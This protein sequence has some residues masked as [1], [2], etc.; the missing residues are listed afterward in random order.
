MRAV[1]GLGPPCRDG[2]DWVNGVH[3]LSLVVVGWGFMHTASL[4]LLALGV[5]KYVST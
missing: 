1:I 4:S 5:S 3:V 2:G